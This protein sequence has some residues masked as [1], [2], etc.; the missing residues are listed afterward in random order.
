MN[1]N[2][3]LNDIL[4]QKTELEKVLAYCRSEEVENKTKLLAEKSVQKVLFSGM[5]SSHFC[6]YGAHILLHQNGIDSRVVS[7]GELLHYEM[8]SLGEETVLC[9]ISQSGE[10][11]EVVHLIE[12]LPKDVFVIAVTN[13]AQSTLARRGNVTFLLN[14]SDELSVT[15]RT[16]LSSL[17]LVQLIAVG[18]CGGN[19]EQVLAEYEKTL[20]GM[21]SYLGNYVEEMQ[22]IKDFCA[23]MK[24]ISLI[25]RGN[26]L[27]SAHAGALFMREVVKFPAMDFDSAEFRHGPME[28]VQDDFYA[29]VFAPAGRT[30]KLNAELAA[31]IAEKGGHV[32]LITDE[33]GALTPS[34]NMMQ[35]ILPQ[36]EEYASQLL[37]ILPVQLLANALA[38]EKQIPVGV[39]RWGSKIMTRE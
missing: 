26:G 29:I 30:Q 27:S 33:E 3:Y 17:L 22:Q 13:Q 28:M 24:V 11:A 16:Y 37:Q 35:I 10:S 8:G 23:G 7:T 31:N 2:F 39:F 21:E 25:G 34:P 5:G 1:E 18:L 14:V 36:V 9:L 20:L 4:T 38:E 6:A 15:T 32:V 19:T 12:R